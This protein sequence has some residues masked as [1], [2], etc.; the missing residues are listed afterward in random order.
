MRGTTN[1]DPQE[2]AEQLREARELWNGLNRPLD[3]A[4]CDLL[5]G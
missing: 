4:A 3:A 1:D 5:I 2:G